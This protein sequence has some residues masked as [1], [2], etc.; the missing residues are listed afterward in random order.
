[1]RASR[2]DPCPCGS[3][4]KYKACCM[5]ADQ[6]ADRVDELLGGGAGRT[7]VDAGLAAARTSTTWAVE[8]VP[9][10]TGFRNDPDGRP[11]L[12]IVMADGF[13]VRGDV[14][15]RRPHSLAERAA[16]LA[17]GI[18]AAGRTA[19]LLPERVLVR[20]PETAAALQAEL[21]GRGIRVE[22]GL[23]PEMDEALD[24][25]LEH[26]C[27]SDVHARVVMPG[28]WAETEATPA[29]LEALHAAAADFYSAAPWTSI[30][31]TRPLLLDFADGSQWA[32]SVMGG[33]GI[34]T[35]LAIYSELDDLYTLLDAEN[36]LAET[37]LNLAGTSLSVTFDPR[38]TLDRAMQREVAKAGW[39]VA[40][41][42]AYPKMIVIHAPERRA[43]P[44]HVRRITAALRAI[45]VVSTGGDPQTA[46]GV[47]V[48]LV[49]FTDD[50]AWPAP[51]AAT[52]CLP[53]GPGA[54]PAAGYWDALP[55]AELARVEAER[56][57]R[58]ATW[59]NRQ[60]KP[61]KGLRA[62][63]LRNGEH[64]AE[65]LVAQGMP[66]GAVTEYELRLFVF[67]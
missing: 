37:F 21:S 5:A 25:S 46:C 22:A 62:A 65:F 2:N 27:E 11:S 32:A 17:A 6:A 50:A 7:A 8:Y 53:A 64:W 40:G 1:M 19:G 39:P 56:L 23:P 61:T 18:S 3:G 9:F 14:Q 31:D 52:P 47:K 48:T 34:E 26:M 58:L 41:P 54:D 10:S 57:A 38:G 4:K 29:E 66:A 16:M 30:E 20:D 36:E 42:D 24:G 43:T 55:P 67:G 33:G 60:K 45:A 12:V 51:E 59:L 15:S 28:A 13:I 44:A 49:A 63:T 35:G